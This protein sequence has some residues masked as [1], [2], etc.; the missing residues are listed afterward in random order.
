MAPLR[1]SASCE[2]P[3]HPAAILRLGTLQAPVQP[4]SVSGTP[5]AEVVGEV[6]DT[7]LGAVNATD[8]FWQLT[9]PYPQYVHAVCITWNRLHAPAIAC[10][11]LKA[12]ADARDWQPLEE[13]TWKAAASTMHIN[14]LPLSPWVVPVRRIVRAL[15]ISLSG[16][17]GAFRPP[18]SAS[19]TAGSKSS[20]SQYQRHGMQS[21]V[22][23]VHDLFNLRMH[24]ATVAAAMHRALAACVRPATPPAVALHAVQAA[25]SLA[26]STGSVRS[27][28]ALVE[29]AL[30]VAAAKSTSCAEVDQVPQASCDGK[31]PAHSSSPARTQALNASVV[32]KSAHD[33]GASHC[34]SL[35]AQ[36][37]GWLGH[38]LEQTL[39]DE[40]RAAC[41]ALV[42][43]FDPACCSPSAHFSTDRTVV[44][45][46][47]PQRAVAFS[48]CGGNK[49][50]MT[51]EFKCLQE[52]RSSDKLYFGIGLKPTPVATSM[53]LSNMWVYSTYSGITLARGTS[54][55]YVRRMY[56]DEVARFELDFTTGTCSLSIQG[57]SVGVLFTG[58]QGHMLACRHR[59]I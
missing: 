32:S 31:K 35:C 38:R 42:P 12:R 45:F 16:H 33:F 13:G 43:A 17:A 24:T 49:G 48:A 4:D 23:H 21:V 25:Q 2:T 56:K 34:A 8:S 55:R 18:T 7:W 47:P 52:P 3:T 19:T 37:D 5:N 15:H 54:G 20:A 6:G 28:L 51:W 44:A 41:A 57:A 36:L 26:L 46:Q 14:S 50:R 39:G 59:E 58:L 30:S 40:A 29:S 27:L 9:L 10:V 22:V 53:T 11:A 1:V